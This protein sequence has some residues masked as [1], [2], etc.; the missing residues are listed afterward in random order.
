MPSH[1]ERVRRNYHEIGVKT[2]QDEQTNE[3]VIVTRV[4][5][6]TLATLLS[7][8]EIET[9]IVRAWRRGVLE[10]RELP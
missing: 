1:P 10:S 3:F 7:R 4:R 9:A 8:R 2:W 6:E 5:R